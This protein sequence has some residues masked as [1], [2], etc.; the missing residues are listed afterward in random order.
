MR[1][2]LAALLLVGCAETHTPPTPRT[3]DLGEC[4]QLA[5]S[6]GGIAHVYALPE[7]YPCGEGGQ[8]RAGACTLPA[9]ET[10]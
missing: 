2:V 1:A 3:V 5:A 4:V 6:D 8:C 10:P 9:Q 7:G